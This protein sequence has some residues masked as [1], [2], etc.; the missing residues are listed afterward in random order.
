M[1]NKQTQQNTQS[2]I[3]SGR[4][5]KSGIACVCLQTCRGTVSKTDV[6]ELSCWE[7]PRYRSESHRYF[8]A[9]KV[10]D[11]RMHIRYEDLNS[12]IVTA[13]KL[14]TSKILNTRCVK[15]NKKKV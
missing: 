12:M 4:R 2:V 6:G 15:K 14:T 10:T 5:R 7:M 11:I 9:H 1:T 13:F 8:G 3:C